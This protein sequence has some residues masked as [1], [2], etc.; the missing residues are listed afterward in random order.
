M[1]IFVVDDKRLVFHRKVSRSLHV[2]CAL[3]HVCPLLAA[4]KWYDMKGSGS[5]IYQ[6]GSWMDFRLDKRL[7]SKVL[8]RFAPGALRQK[9][10]DRAVADCVEA[11]AGRNAQGRC[12]ALAGNAGQ[13]R[14]NAG[15]GPVFAAG[16]NFW[17]LG[18]A[19]YWGHNAIIRA[20]PFMRWCEL[21]ADR[22]GQ[23]TVHLDVPATTA[24]D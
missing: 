14:K 20:E 13:Q 19:Q 22:D 15:P 23:M 1:S 21:P 16:Q 24:V 5:I 17:Q 11:G 2:Y 8:A 6:L 10:R 4:L 18:D 9:W 12:S 3:R 7:S